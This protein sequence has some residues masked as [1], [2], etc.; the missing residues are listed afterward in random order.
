MKGVLL[1]LILTVT[2]LIAED[3][4]ADAEKAEQRDLQTKLAEAG[5][6]SVDFVRALEQHLR[7]YPDTAQRAELEYALVKAA[8]EAKD[9]RRTLEYGEKVLGR[10][11]DDPRVLERVT[12]ILLNN[13]DR[14][15]NER[16]LKYARKFEEIAKKYGKEATSSAS[17]KAQQSEESDRQVGKALVFEAR[18]SGN[19]DQLDEALKLARKSYELYPTAESAREIGRWLAK[20]GKDWEAVPH[21]ADALMIADPRNTDIDRTQDRAKLAELYAKAKHNGPSLG[22]IVLE[23]YDRTALLMAQRLADQRKT[24]PNVSLADVMQYTVTSLD[25]AKLNLASLKGKVVILDFWATWCGPCRIQHPLYDEVKKKFAA[26]PNIVFLAI[27]TDEDQNLVKPFLTGQNWDTKNVYFEDGLTSFLRVS[28]IPATL[29]IDAT[30]HIYSRMNGFL[31]ERFVSMLSERI[32][33]AL[34][35]Q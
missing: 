20:A 24:D 9:D 31:P 22:D 28:S 10:G 27:A 33:E 13:T 5:N 3:K 11:N 4:K 34:E 6:S 25:G 23:A 30:G 35:I 29:V 26:N 19:L 21:F 16:A 14:E 1:V 2:F 15:S 32:S 8:L 17:A 12:R 18:A 7:K